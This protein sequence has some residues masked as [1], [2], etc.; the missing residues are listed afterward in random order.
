MVAIA[1]PHATIP[2][3]PTIVPANQD[4]METVKTAAKVN[5]N[6]RILS[7][8]VFKIPQFVKRR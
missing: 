8:N 4:L 5:N 2:K 3:A 1:T 7:R 6:I